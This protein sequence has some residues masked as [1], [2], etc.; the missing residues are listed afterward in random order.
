MH[1][2]LGQ[3]VPALEHFIAAEK[4]KSGLDVDQAALRYKAVVFESRL[5]ALQRTAELESLASLGGLVGA[6]AHEINSPLGAIQSSANV[7]M[8]AADKLAAGHDPKAVVALRDNAQV[9]TDASRRISELV[10]RLKLLAG[11][12]QARYSRIDV[13]R[14][15][16]DVVALLRPEFD[17][18]V[19]VS[20]EREDVG[21]LIYGYAT[22]LYQVFLNLLRN[23][24]QAIEGAGAVAI[25]ISA[26]N[27]WFRISFADTGRGIPVLL[28]PQL[29]TPGFSAESG[30][31][32][33]SLSLFTCM[34]VIKKHGGD[35]HVESEVGLGS[36]FTVLLPRSL[37]KSDPKLES[38]GSAAQ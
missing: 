7:S 21:L 2:Q 34:V 1:Q 26:D 22:E 37:E 27:D 35:I 30:R 38:P 23:C 33:A 29:F 15:V 32:R 18:R 17:Q 6:I 19:S 31:V 12:D 25:R 10:T 24:I 8:L 13:G 3:L 9:I 4:V 16:D 36:T 11:I 14:A 5:E 20:V 28:L